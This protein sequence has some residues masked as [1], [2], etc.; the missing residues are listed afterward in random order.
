MVSVPTEK[1]ERENERQGQR[2]LKGICASDQYD[3]GLLFALLW[4]L[5]QRRF[6]FDR[7]GNAAV[8]CRCWIDRIRILQM[9][10]GGLTMPNT[11]EID[12]ET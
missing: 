11:K 6:A 7:F 2:L 8:T 5:V 9:D 3:Y 10:K 1:G 4:H 12:H